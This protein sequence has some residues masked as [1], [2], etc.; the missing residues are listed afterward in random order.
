MENSKVCHSITHSSPSA[1]NSFFILP[2]SSETSKGIASIQP[3]T[4]RKSFRAK[5]LLHVART[6]ALGKTSKAILDSQSQ[7][8]ERP[9][10]QN[11]RNNIHFHPYNLYIRVQVLEGEFYLKMGSINPQY[12]APPEKV[13]FQGLLFDSELS[14]EVTMQL[15]SKSM[16]CS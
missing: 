2:P 11:K 10:D 1:P 5:V 14:F 15:A 9:L 8:V 12:S 13:L 7:L 3:I 4:S 6:L 16:Y